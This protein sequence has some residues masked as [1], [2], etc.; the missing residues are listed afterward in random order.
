MKEVDLSPAAVDFSMA[1]SRLSVISRLALMPLL[2][3][4]LLADPCHS[5]QSAVRSETWTK[6][7]LTL[8]RTTALI[9]DKSFLTAK[10]GET[11]I[12]FRPVSSKIIPQSAVILCSKADVLEQSFVFRPISPES[13]LESFVG[14]NVLLVRTDK[15]TGSEKTV[16]AKLLSARNGIVLEIGG[17][18]ETSVPGRIAFPELPQGIG[19]KPMLKIKLKGRTDGNCPLE[20]AY[21]TRGISW[22]ADYTVI[23]DKTESRIA[24]NSWVTISN[25]SGISFKDAAVQ[26]VAGDVNEEALPPRINRKFSME[27]AAAPAMSRDVSRQG[28]FEYHLYSIGRLVSLENGVLK[29]I[30]LFSSG[31]VP[32]RK[33]FFAS[34]NAYAYSRRMGGKE[35]KLPVQAVISFQNNKDSALG[36]PMPQG[37]VRVFKRDSAGSLQF[38]GKDRITHVPEGEKIRLNL[39]KAF[40]IICT[41]VQADFEKLAGSKYSSTYESSYKVTFKNRKD[42]PVSVKYMEPVPGTW[43]ITNENLKHEKPDA[44]T[45]VWTLNIPAKGQKALIFSIRVRY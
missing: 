12:L 15:E 14:K 43:R 17:R 39:G 6:T 30:S 34:G 29:Q 33:E 2:A 25:N 36:I 38:I 5:G 31:D 9:R 27:K 20:L 44:N 16:P 22:S 37:D 41:R 28:I 23:L 40:D 7:S 42:E 45:A 35:E 8:Y 1:R 19:E 3:F 13:I 32:C 21:L 26:M 10:K 18:I 24:L 4:C 11:T